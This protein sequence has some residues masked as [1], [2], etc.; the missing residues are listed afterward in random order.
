M[1][2]VCLHVLTRARSLRLWAELVGLPSGVGI[3][4]ELDGGL[5]VDRVSFTPGEVLG[6]YLWGP[7]RQTAVID[8][9]ILRYDPY[10]QEPESMLAR[11]LSWQWKIRSTT[12]T[13]SK[14]YRVST[15]L[16]ES[17][18][19]LNID[20]PRR[21]RERLEKMLETLRRDGIIRSWR[22]QSWS[23]ANA[24]RVGWAEP[25]L[26][27]LV[28]I[29]PPA[30]VVSYY[31][32]NLRGALPDGEPAPLADRLR[33]TRER[34]ELTQERAAEAV[35]ISQQAYSRAERGKGVSP[36][37]RGKLQAWIREP[38]AGEHPRSCSIALEQRA[39]LPKR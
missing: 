38:Y 30:P 20:E 13:Y 4:H 11:Y 37:N 2:H 19:Q 1:H 17:R 22:Y 21:T 29:E 15:L 5:D 36:A 24:P 33:R 27:E 26:Q 14:P 16:K 25:W 32:K 31:L 35:E 7:G 34:L 3:P 6:L 23:L 10:R 9:K 12:G 28:S 18:L 8:A 39:A